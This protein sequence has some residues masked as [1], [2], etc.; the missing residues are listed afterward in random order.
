MEEIL[1]S[2]A[3]SRADYGD[4]STLDPRLRSLASKYKFRK[5]SQDQEE[6]VTGATSQPTAPPPP[7]SSTPTS[8]PPSPPPS[9]SLFPSPLNSSPT[10]QV[11]E[12]A[13]AFL[14]D[15][16]FLQLKSPGRKLFSF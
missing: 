8:P 11:Q 5:P 16:H 10:S 1:Y 9:A 14:K 2:D 4:R 12:T 15:L 3:Q 13:S 6:P 7:A